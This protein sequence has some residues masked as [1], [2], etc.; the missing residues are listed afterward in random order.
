MDHLE[1]GHRLGWME[2]TMQ[3][4]GRRL[5][6]LEQRRPVPGPEKAVKR[7]LTWGLPPA[8]LL[9]TGNAELA[10]EVM[11]AVLGVGR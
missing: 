7:L 5:S 3:E 4:H 6:R 11:K 9:L 10:L 2:A 1:L 8:T